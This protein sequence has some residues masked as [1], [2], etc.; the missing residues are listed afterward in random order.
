MN[1]DYP[2]LPK[3]VEDNIRQRGG[4]LISLTNIMMDITNELVMKYSPYIGTSYMVTLPEAIAREKDIMTIKYDIEDSLA[5]HAVHSA[6][7]FLSVMNHALCFSDFEKW[8]DSQC[9]KIENRAERRKM[10]GKRQHVI[11]RRPLNLKS[12]ITEK[13]FIEMIRKDLLDRGESPEQIEKYFAEGCIQ[14]SL[15][16]KPVEFPNNSLYNKDKGKKKKC[17]HN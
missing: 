9:A 5:G 8:Y 13:E 6:L 16:G 10:K 4:E 12:G 2:Q 7:S 17:K 1:N 15:D 3:E 11:L 14:A